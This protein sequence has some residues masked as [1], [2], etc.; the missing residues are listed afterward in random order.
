MDSRQVAPTKAYVRHGVP[1]HALAWGATQKVTF[2]DTFR[3]SISLQPYVRLIFCLYCWIVQFNVPRLRFNMNHSDHWPSLQ[4][5]AREGCPESLHGD[6]SRTAEPIAPNFFFMRMHISKTT[7]GL[8]QIQ[9]VMSLA[10]V[11]S[12]FA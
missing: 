12:S 8:G 1:A 9:N 6:N 2:F 5:E 11:Q 7:F 10:L 3:T 4:R